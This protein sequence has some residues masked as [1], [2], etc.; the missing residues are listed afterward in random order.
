MADKPGTH[1]C[2]VCVNVNCHVCLMT[3]QLFVLNDNVELMLSSPV[4]MFLISEINVVNSLTLCL[5]FVFI[6]IYSYRE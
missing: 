1:T 2:H 5:A 4:L 6:K 3:L